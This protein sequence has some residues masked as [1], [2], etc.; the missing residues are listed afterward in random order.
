M[1]E[2]QSRRLGETFLLADRE[3]LIPEHGVWV[4]APRAEHAPAAADLYRRAYDRSDF[5][6][7]RYEDPDSSIFNP[8]WLKHD[9]EDNPDHKWFVFTNDTGEILGITGFFHDQNIDGYP[10]MTS[11]ETQIAPEGRGHRIMDHFFRRIVPRIEAAGSRLATSFVLT[12]QTKGLR[13]TLETEEGMFSLGILPHALKHRASGI[14]KSEIVS[15]KFESFQ[16]QPVSLEANFEPL[17]RIVQSQIPELPEPT[18]LPAEPNTGSVFAETY[19]E[20]PQ[21]ASGAD[22]EQQ[23]HLLQAGFKPVAYYPRFNGFLA[24]KIPQPMPELDFIF[25]ETIDANKDLV[26]YLQAEL[27]NRNE[28]RL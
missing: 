17:Y 5:F 16:H 25:D 7:G 20:A 21:L 24:A 26:R 12:P 6:A 19:E 23:R 11:D 9:F 22:P 4:E 3:L 8:R 1:G 10:V 13:R 27:Y 28:G 14:T 15:A 2:R 18:V